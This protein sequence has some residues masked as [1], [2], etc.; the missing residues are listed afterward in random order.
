VIGNIIIKKKQKNQTK[1]QSS[2]Q[3]KPEMKKGF[4]RAKTGLPTMLCFTIKQNSQ[5]IKK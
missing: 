2:N 1:N 3:K 4:R 5:N